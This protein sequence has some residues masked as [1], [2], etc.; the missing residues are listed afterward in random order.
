MFIAALLNIAMTW[1]QPKYP[2]NR[3]MDKENRVHI[4]NGVLFSHK[5]E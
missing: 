4:C 1:K 5:K 2:I 3:G